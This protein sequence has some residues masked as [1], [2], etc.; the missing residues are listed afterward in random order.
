[1][2]FAVRGVVEADSPVIS[3]QP[4]QFPAAKLRA[5]RAF[6]SEVPKIAE[7]SADVT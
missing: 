1:M 5:V 2:H 3:T 6:T 4:W 7:H